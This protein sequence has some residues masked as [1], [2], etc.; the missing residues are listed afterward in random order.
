MMRPAVIV[1]LDPTSNAGSHFI[2][3]AILGRPDLLFLQAAMEPFDVAIAFRVTIGRAAMDDAEHSRLFTGP[4]FTIP[5]AGVNPIPQKHA[6]LWEVD[7]LRTLSFTRTIY[8][9]F[10]FA[11]TI[12]RKFASQYLLHGAYV[13]RLQRDVHESVTIM[14][15][16]GWKIAAVTKLSLKPAKNE[17]KRRK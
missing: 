3:A 7:E 14:W 17:Q 16:R 9:C 6:A 8:L 10:I 5:L 2:Q 12:L 1:R 11:R 4:D 15:R 13:L